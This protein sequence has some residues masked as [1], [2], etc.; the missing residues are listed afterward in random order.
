MSN[1]G[2]CQAYTE[3]SNDFL[4]CEVQAGQVPQSVIINH[5]TPGEDYRGIAILIRLT[6][7]VRNPPSTKPSQPFS[8]R[9]ELLDSTSNTYY[10]VDRN[11]QNVSVTA[12]KPNKF[13]KVTV[14]RSEEEVSS[15]T[16]LRFCLTT[17][18]RV[19][20]NSRLTIIYPQD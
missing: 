10:L 17:S 14:T 18:N 13:D 15:F 2:E 5:D 7:K 8:L 12:N 4:N 20:E 3:S 11:A 16:D 9:S 19:P 6:N 1:G